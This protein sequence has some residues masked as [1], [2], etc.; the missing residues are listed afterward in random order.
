[1]KN[2]WS[3][4]LQNKKVL[5][6]FTSLET[7]PAVTEEKVSCEFSNRDVWKPFYIININ[8]SEGFL[9]YGLRQK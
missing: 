9:S 5:F 4:C 8:T 3:L 1:M 2:N 7:H 6:L